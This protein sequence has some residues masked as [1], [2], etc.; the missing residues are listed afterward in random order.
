MPV[1]PYTIAVRGLTYSR[2]GRD[3][4]H[5]RLAEL[6]AGYPE[7]VRGYGLGSFDAR[8]CDQ[9]GAGG[10]CVIFNNLRGSGVGVV[11]VEVRAPLMGIFRHDLDYGRLPIELSGFAD[12]GLSW[13]RLDAP[14]FFGGT[15][16]AVRS[17]GVA[18][19]V[20]VFSLLVLEFSAA[21][22]FDRPGAGV[23]WQILMRPGY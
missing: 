9:V 17:A 2:W 5:P 19:R 4:E 14:V 1:K 10:Q 11:N 13:S 12:A 21:H 18:V 22:P 15:H 20:N 7:L 16:Q 23:Q 3:G 8:D 6:Y